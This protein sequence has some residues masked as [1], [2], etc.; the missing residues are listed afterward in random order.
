LE[1]EVHVRRDVLSVLLVLA[2]CGGDGGGGT[3][4]G[5]S[6]AYFPLAVGAEWTY[7]ITDTATTATKQK[8]TTIEAFEKVGGDKSGVTAYRIR[9]DKLSGE[10]VSW[11]RVNGDVLERHREQSFDNGDMTREEYYEPF[12][13]RLDESAAHIATSAAWT[14][15]YSE[16]AIDYAAG[17]TTST[18]GKSDQWS[19][20]AV[21]EQLTV[22]AGTYTC[23]HL[24]KLSTGSDKHYWFAKDVGKIK[25]SGGGQTE[26]LVSYDPP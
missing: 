15:T 19:V 11:Q 16:R 23:L 5:G 24:H 12:K 9:T 18:S 1:V 7:L 8:T 26:E 2:A 20:V 4:N 10:T 21:E 3:V 6:L 22:P 14:D 25:E 13:L 17:G